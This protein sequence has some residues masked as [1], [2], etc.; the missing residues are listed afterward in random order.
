MKSLLLSVYGKIF[1]AFPEYFPFKIP[2]SVQMFNLQILPRG[3]NNVAEQ[4]NL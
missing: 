3:Q 2:N 1:L 4:I